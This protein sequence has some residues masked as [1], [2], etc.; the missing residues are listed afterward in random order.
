[1][2]IPFWWNLRQFF[3]RVSKRKSIF[4]YERVQIWANF[5]Q[6]SLHKILKLLS[7]AISQ[8]KGK[9]ILQNLGFEMTLVV[10][11]TSWF[12][13][14]AVPKVFIFLKSWIAQSL[15]RNIYWRL[16]Y[17]KNSITKPFGHSMESKNRS[18]IFKQTYRN[19]LNISNK[20]K[21]GEICTF[22]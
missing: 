2:H 16:S 18:L 6:K 22:L 13:F 3:T 20:Q 14:H 11:G 17:V 19:T 7:S 1:M 15:F 21:M 10:F 9:K 5:F 8:F 12:R 4:L